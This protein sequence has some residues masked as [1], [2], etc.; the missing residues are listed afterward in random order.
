M[1]LDFF[2]VQVW[3]PLDFEWPVR[4][5]FHSVFGAFAKTKKKL[6]FTT[7][8]LKLESANN[9]EHRQYG[10]EIHAGFL[11]LFAFHESAAG[12]ALKSF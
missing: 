2:G 10:G 12:C 9:E 7:V 1:L 4:L 6:C 11:Y 5:V 8:P 3:R